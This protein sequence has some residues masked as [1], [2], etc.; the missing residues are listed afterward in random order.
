ML[1]IIEN[2]LFMNFRHWR[3]KTIQDIKK[4]Q[5]HK[6]C[7]FLGSINAE[8]I[9]EYFH[10]A[11]SFG[12]K[13]N[14]AISANKPK[15]TFLLVT[16]VYVCIVASLVFRVMLSFMSLPWCFVWCYHSCLFPG[17][18]C[19]VIIHVSSLVFRVMLSFMSLPWCFVWCYHSCLFP[20]VSCDVIIHVSSLVFRVMLSFMSLPW[21]FVWCYHLCP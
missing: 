15:Y 5:I 7:L 17:V 14:T 6:I 11:Y 20:G 16:S 2:M 10:A 18:S 21:C 12:C 8:L 19:D 4:R 13:I 3:S 9:T 1:M